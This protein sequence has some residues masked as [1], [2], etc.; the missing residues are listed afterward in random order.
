[1]T[2]KRHSAEQNIKM[3]R[4]ADAVVR[5]GSNYDEDVG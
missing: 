1:M 3:L 2:G 5:V 4:D